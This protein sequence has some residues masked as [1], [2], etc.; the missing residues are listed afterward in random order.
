M[1]KNQ[2]PDT[3]TTTNT[4]PMRWRL[5]AVAAATAVA[6]SVTVA[7]VVA[8]GSTPPAAQAAVVLTTTT[9]TTAPTDTTPVDA[10]TD[11]PAPQVEQEAPV[12]EEQPE[13]A[14]AEMSVPE[15][16]D[17]DENNEATIEITN[18]GDLDLHMTFIGSA[19]A[20]IDSYGSV[21]TIAGGESDSFHVVVDDS[22]LPFGAYTINVIVESD[23]G[24]EVVKVKGFKKL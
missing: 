18:T 6:A 1:T 5:A 24:S 8:G 22:I 17:L 10:D 11:T 20:G 19:F 3:N 4:T 13:L 23:G 14:P 7:A 21:G 12:E 9:T 15:S 16:V 2:T